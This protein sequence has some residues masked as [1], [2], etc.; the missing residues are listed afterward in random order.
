MKKQLTISII[1]QTISFTF[2][3]FINFFLTQYIV[4]HIGGEAYGFVGLANNFIQYAQLITVALNSMASRFITIEISKCEYNNAE[5]YFASLLIGNLVM[6]LL[7]S[8]I[9]IILIMNLEKIINISTYLVVDVKVLW[10][11]MVVNFIINLISSIYAISTFAKNRLDLVSKYNVISNI[12]KFILLI[13]MCYTLKPKIWFVGFSSIIASI[14][15]LFMNK[16]YTK[17]LLPQISIKYKY[18]DFNIL[19][20]LISSGIWSSLSKLSSILSSGLDLLIT[21]ILIG[22]NAMGIISIVKTIPLMIISL[23]SV[24]SDVFTPQLTINYAKNNIEQIKSDLFIA[25]KFISFFSTIIIVAFIVLGKD[26]YSLWIPNENA[27]I[28]SILSAI[29]CGYLI[30][31]IPLQPLNSIFVVVNKLKVS[32]ISVLISSVFIIGIEMMFIPMINDINTKIIIIILSTAI[33]ELIRGILFIPIYSSN[34]L[35]IKWYTFY[36]PI[37]KNILSAIILFIVYSLIY[38]NL[39]IS[40]WPQLIMYT[41]SYLIIGIII[42]SIIIFNKHDRKKIIN[43]I[44]KKSEV[45]FE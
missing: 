22:P 3:I 44:I 8:P 33:C 5:K 38:N 15:I 17:K 12:I 26:F 13:F 21:N 43:F 36:N 24:I 32:S 20:K 27:N 39:E 23:F 18:F 29:A 6:I 30:I 10:L 45:S 14:F 7:L 11:F 35:N 31:L 25:I 19:K 4:N 34:C 42:N 1:Y 2:N 41:T 9:F 40:T 16:Y 37:L 28:L